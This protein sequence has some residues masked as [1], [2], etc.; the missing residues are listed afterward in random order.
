[1]LSHL[2]DKPGV[3][4]GYFQGIENWGQALVKLD[5]H[6]GTNDRNDTPAGGGSSSGRSSIIPA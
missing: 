1:M 6:Y 2:Q 5:V 4:A 3:T